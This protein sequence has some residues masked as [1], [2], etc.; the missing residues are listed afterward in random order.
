MIVDDNKF[1]DYLLPAKEAIEEFSFFSD[2]ETALGVTSLEGGNFDDS[3]D[4]GPEWLERI[5]HQYTDY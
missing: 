3:L 2:D 5:S 4:N 1:E